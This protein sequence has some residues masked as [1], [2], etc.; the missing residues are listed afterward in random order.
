MK[1]DK[2][3]YD[4]HVRLFN[5]GDVIFRENEEGSEMFVIVEGRVE[6][7]KATGP[8]T[9]KTLTVLQKGD[10]FGEMAIIEKMPRSAT[11]VALQPT[12]LLVLNEKLYEA[13]VGTNPDFAR[14]MN[15]VLSERIRRANAIIQNIMSTN[16]QNQLWT[17]LAQYAQ[18]HG[19][20][21]YKGS[22]VSVAEFTQWAQEHLGMS[23]KEVQALLAQFLKREVIAYSARGKE[24]ILIAPKAGEVLPEG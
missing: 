19:V 23:E 24:E 15:R 7:R 8:S 18:E 6:I 4:R 13:T 2:G 21:T 10:M 1:I 11:A 12:R 16:R 20:A 3:T 17:G 9:S 5:A 14:K 22:R